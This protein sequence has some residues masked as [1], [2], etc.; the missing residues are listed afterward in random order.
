MSGAGKS[1][2]IGA[3]GA[4]GYKAIDTDAD[5]W[6]EW[7]DVDGE[8]DYRWR[9]DRIQ[10]LLATEDA[11]VLFV[12][13]CKSNQG[14][15]RRYFDHIVLLSAPAPVLVARVVSRTN[16]PYGKQPDE[17][18]RILRDIEAVEPLLRRS[19]TL[20]VD[21]SAPLEQVVASLLRLVRP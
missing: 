15:F 11:D 17:L 1:T 2:V 16:N 21:A 5:A 3:L 20:E 9:E 8:P 6:S 19:A 13:G 4:L 14:K 7:V 12:G 10:H 18:A